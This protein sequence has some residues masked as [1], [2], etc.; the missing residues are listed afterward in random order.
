MD[1]DNAADIHFAEVH[2]VMH[3][4]K[5]AGRQSERSLGYL[6][7]GEMIPKPVLVLKKMI[8]NPSQY[9]AEKEAYATIHS[10]GEEEW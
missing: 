5:A 2:C 8:A 1:T 10:I 6:H 9:R 4:Q 7:D 3:K